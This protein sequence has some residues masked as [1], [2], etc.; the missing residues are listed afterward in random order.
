MPLA[1]LAPVRMHIPDGFLSVVVSLL[2]WLLAVAAIAFA[3]RQTRGQLGSK[4]I[5]LMGVLAAFIFAA[6]AINFPVA[7]GTSGHLLG[8]TLAAIVLGPWAAVLVM[9][10]V[11][12]VQALLFQDG[13]LLVLG[14]NIVNMGIITAFSGHLVYQVAR[15]LLGRGRNSLLV[16]GALGAWVSVVLGAA[17]TAVE[18]AASG[19][20][21]LSIALPS[22]VG[23]HG[24]IGLGEAAITV[25]ALAFIYSSRRDLLDLGEAAPARS[26]A[27]WAI[28]GLLIALAVAALSPLASPHPDGLNRV[29]QD[30]GFQQRALGPLFHLLSNY[31]VPLISNPVVSKVVAVVGGTLVVFGA[32]LFVARLQRKAAA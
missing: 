28:A 14:F 15:R 22:M 16:A 18:L 9:T 17:A 4:Q 24:L 10:S 12:G 30:L 19:T 23:I 3:L 8:G 21:P 7:G 5:P 31:S 26:A 20:S 1:L 13:G 11:I 2:G 29:A 27:H 25:G 32:A 6:Q